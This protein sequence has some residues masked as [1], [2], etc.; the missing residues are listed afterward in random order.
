M[1]RI[2]D[3]FDARHEAELVLIEL[4]ALLVLLFLLGSGAASNP[5]SPGVA[6]PGAEPVVAPAPAKPVNQPAAPAPPAT[7]GKH[8][9]RRR[10][11]VISIPDRKL[12][13]LDQGTVVKVYPV[14]VG[15]AGSPSP[16]GDFTIVCRASDPAYRHNR[17]FI[18][19]GKK[20]P[21]GA[22]WLGL[23]KAHYGIH[24]TN[25]PGSIGHAASHGCI[26]MNNQDVRELFAQ[27]EVGDG[28]E[29]HG[30]RDPGM[31]K[32][33]GEPAPVEEG[34]STEDASEQL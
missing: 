17:Q 34:A 2:G 15:A 32:I 23:S 19:P 28:V 18:P 11:V 7:V 5:V 24:G 16:S 12:A 1:R 13:V 10:R 9:S 14:A 25:D 26:R 31:E 21:L 30:Q 33:F 8:T 4:F 27:V 3:A 6:T 29:I 20:N 22:R